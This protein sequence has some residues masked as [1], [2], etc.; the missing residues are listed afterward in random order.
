MLLLCQ[1]NRQCAGF[2]SVRYSRCCIW[3]A[4]VTAPSDFQKGQA[5]L[6]RAFEP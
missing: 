5:L 6:V 1:L 4:L 3:G 2:G